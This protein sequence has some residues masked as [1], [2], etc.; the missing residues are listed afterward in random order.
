M[1]PARLLVACLALLLAAACSKITAENFGRV[2]EGMTESE[3]AAILGPPTES[4]AISLLGIT[5]TNSRWV[6]K[7]HVIAMQFVNGKVRVKELAP[8][9]A[10]KPR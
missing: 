8:L 3:V 9:D 5:G 10:P 4:S 7:E 6:G 2:K 1:Q